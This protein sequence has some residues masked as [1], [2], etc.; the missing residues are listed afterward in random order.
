[1]V[2]YFVLLIMTM[3]GA[4]A[5]FCLKKAVEEH[6]STWVLIRNRLFVIGGT[7]YFSSALLNIYILKFLPYSVVLPFTAITYI[8][9]LM[10]AKAFLHEKIGR[11]KKTGMALIVGGV[12]LIAW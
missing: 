4:M 11:S 3:L 5:A 2:V 8:W 9:T 6:T 10:L 1:M 7:L 12:I